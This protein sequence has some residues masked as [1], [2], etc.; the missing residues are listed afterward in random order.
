MQDENMSEI[1]NMQK[2]EANQLFSKFIDNNYVDY[3][4]N[5][6]FISSKNIL[7]KEI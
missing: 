6:D 1:F 4:N 7:K 3:L 5:S 2:D